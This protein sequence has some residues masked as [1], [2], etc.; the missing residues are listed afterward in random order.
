MTDSEKDSLQ[1]MIDKAALELVQHCDSVIILA[2]RHQG[3]RRTQAFN[4]FEG[5]F[6][7]CLGQAKDWVTLQDAYHINQAK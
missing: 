4:A 2:T 6:Y 5:N 7:A 3:Q 1:Q